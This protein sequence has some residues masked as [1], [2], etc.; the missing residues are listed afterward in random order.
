MMAEGYIFGAGGFLFF[1]VWLLLGC[2]DAL[3][4]NKNLM[5]AGNNII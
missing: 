3:G 4:R 5:M 2:I 1:S